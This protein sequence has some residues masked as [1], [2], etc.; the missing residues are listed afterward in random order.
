MILREVHLRLGC[1]C[2]RIK[3]RCLPH[4]RRAPRRAQARTHLYQESS[5]AATLHHHQ[6]VIKTQLPPLLIIS[7]SLE[8]P[9]L[10]PCKGRCFFFWQPS[11]DHFNITMVHHNSSFTLSDLGVLP[12][13]F[14]AHTLEPPLSLKDNGYPSTR[15]LNDLNIPI[16]PGLPIPECETRLDNLTLK[17]QIQHQGTRN[18]FSLGPTGFGS[19]LKLVYVYIWGSCLYSG[20]LVGAP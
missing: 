14:I 17:P 18:T 19:S 15:L 9:F 13:S 7:P 8:F 5:P 6:Q 16:K 3:H 11:T 12:S 20:Q 4:Y 10:R 2:V 1:L